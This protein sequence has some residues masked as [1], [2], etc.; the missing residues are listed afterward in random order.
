MARTIE[1]IKKEMTDAWL[2]NETLQQAYGFTA[3]SEWLTVYSKV[4]LENIICYI[5][6]AAI[7]THEKLFDVHTAEVEDYIAQMKPHTLRWYVNKVK[8][9]RSGRDLVEG[10]DGYDDTDLTEED[11]A[12]LQPVKFAAASESDATVYMKVATETG[13]VKSPITA[14]QLTGLKAYLAEVKDAGVRVEL[15]NEAGCRLKLTLD[16]YY[17][18]MVLD[19]SGASLADG[20]KPVEAAIKAYIEN[21]PFNG[22][23]RNSALIDALQAVDGVEI[24]ELLSAA[25]SYDGDTYTSVNAKSVPYSGYYV[26]ESDN[27]TLNYYP[28]EYAA[29]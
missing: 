11:I 4:S 28:Y 20:S 3:D 24:P 17:N 16:I 9:F 10:T 5:M 15:I 26:Y 22:E 23:Y 19:S 13:G 27:I 2:K 6:A 1:Q 29:N 25:E 12:A 21:L 14:D 18:P 7:W 8:A